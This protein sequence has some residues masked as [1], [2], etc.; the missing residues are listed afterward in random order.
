MFT[1]ANLLFI[2]C[3]LLWEVYGK[4]YT[5]TIQR[6]EKIDKDYFTKKYYKKKPLVMPSATNYF[7]NTTKK[8][9]SA[10]QQKKFSLAKLPSMNGEEITLK[11]ALL[12]C[13]ND[14]YGIHREEVCKEFKNNI[15]HPLY[16]QNTGELYLSLAKGDIETPPAFEEE[17]IC[18]FQSSG[19]T[20]W[21][22]L[23]HFSGTVDLFSQ[24]FYNTNL[25][26]GDLLYIPKNSIT[27]HVSITKL[28]MMLAFPCGTQLLNSIEV[29]IK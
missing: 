4:T 2:F 6:M 15:S 11:N 25:A 28:S 29:K 5:T 26:T 8:I 21:R 7:K 18:I 13:G 16:L 20:E 14:C 9:F 17:D 22:L 24:H 27:Q 23:T 10:C 3:C 1:L 12:P 19:V